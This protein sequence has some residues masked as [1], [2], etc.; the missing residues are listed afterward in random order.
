LESRRTR[1]IA[2]FWALRDV[3]FEVRKGE[4]VGIIGRNGAGKST[5]LQILC[6]TL[7]PKQRVG[8]RERT[9]RGATRARFWLQFRVFRSREVYLY[10][11]VLGLSRKDVAD[12]FDD[13]AAFA[14]IGDFIDQPIK[15]YSTGMVIRLAFAVITHVDADILVIDEALAV[16]M[17]S[18]YR[19]ACGSCAGS[20]RQ[21]RSCS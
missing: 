1:I 20:W 4:T 9:R 14:D 12:R 21:E 11:S 6:G 2:K 15:T 7:H 17:R 8:Y 3:S 19:N 16:A 10:A 5:L 13:I 18:S